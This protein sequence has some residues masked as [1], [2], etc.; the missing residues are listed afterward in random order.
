[1]L[2]VRIVLNTA[3][4]NLKLMNWIKNH[5]TIEICQFMTAIM[6][7]SNNEHCIVCGT[8]QLRSCHLQVSYEWIIRDFP[9][10]AATWW[11]LRLKSPNIW[12]FNFCRILQDQ[13]STDELLWRDLCGRKKETTFPANTVCTWQGKL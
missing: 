9:V 13:V 11:P 1:M 7:C 10:V 12:P 5:R 6:I 8:L 4:K 2:V 3:W